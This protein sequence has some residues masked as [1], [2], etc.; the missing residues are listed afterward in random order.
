MP[1]TLGDKVLLLPKISLV[2]S[3]TLLSVVT[4]PFRGDE[5][6]DTVGEHVMNTA[7]RTLVTSFTTG[8]LQ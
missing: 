1:S 3:N 5:G 7:V 6:A 4:S 2:I 8:Q